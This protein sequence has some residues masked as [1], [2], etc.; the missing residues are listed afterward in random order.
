MLPVLPLLA[1]LQH[2]QLQLI[3]G[4]AVFRVSGDFSWFSW[5]TLGLLSKAASAAT[6]TIAAIPAAAATK[7]DTATNV[8]IDTLHRMSMCLCTPQ[9]C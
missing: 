5:Y 1:L 2:L 6:A 7:A 9:H 8:A 4:K 3:K